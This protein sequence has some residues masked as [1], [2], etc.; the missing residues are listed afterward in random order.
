MKNQTMTAGDLST[1]SEQ[2]VA[3]LSCR[4]ERSEAFYLGTWLQ[5]LDDDML[6]ALCVEAS[7]FRNDV[8]DSADLATLCAI[9]V[10]TESG[11][12][13]IRIGVG[14]LR[15]WASSLYVAVNLEVAS[16][17]GLIALA[18]P[19]SINLK[20]ALEIRITPEGISAANAANA[21]TSTSR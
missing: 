11:V 5:T 19:L 2:L 20:N 3:F 6:S 17:R 18:A 15:Q 16:R 8:M 7:R 12:P 21:L 9:A 1:F 13:V 10:A 4:T 14:T